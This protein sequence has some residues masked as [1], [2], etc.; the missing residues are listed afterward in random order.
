MNSVKENAGKNKKS[1]ITMLAL[2]VALVAFIAASCGDTVS[3]W[4][5]GDKASSTYKLE[6]FKKKVTD[7]H[8]EHNREIT[9]LHEVFLRDIENA[10]CADFRQAHNN[11]ETTME[12]F[13][14]FKNT[15]YLIYLMA[16]D[17]VT[18]GNSAHD[19]ISGH[20]GPSIISPCLDG[21]EAIRETL[22]DFLHKLQEKN[23]VF[24]AELI[25]KLNKLP[26]GSSEAI[27]GENFI[28]NLEGVDTSINNMVSGKGWFV[29]GAVFEAI[30]I[31]GTIHSLK[32][33]G[34]KVI[35][36]FAGSTAAA[37]VDGPLP[38]GD[39]L[40][41]GGFAWCAY[42]IYHVQ[43]VLPGKLRSALRKSITDYDVES[44]TAARKVAEEALSMCESSA[45]KIVA[46]I[47]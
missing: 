18:S 45:N 34:G 15:A 17:K 47:R 35:A 46:E 37:V 29:V 10:G 43:K 3:G 40:A 16:Y 8:R 24:H 7:L 20:L 32:A 12:Q 13:T 39:I 38:F 11:I 21:N 23:N 2:T 36:K 26:S 1:L 42:D 14:G 9:E 4:F 19:Y 25:Q 30:V 44:R 27:E 22:M 41:V 5:K 28:R 31:K 33:V 6:D